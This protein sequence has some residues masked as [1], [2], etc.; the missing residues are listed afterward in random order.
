[1]QGV[2]I[3]DIAIEAQAFDTIER[4]FQEILSELATDQSLERFRQEF[5]KL[6]RSLKM[7][8]EN[9]RRLISKCR[10][11]NSDIAGSASKVQTALKMTSDDA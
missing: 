2:D 9:Q 1:M 8:H 3:D 10:E 5:D 11:L 4:E 7:S 6:H